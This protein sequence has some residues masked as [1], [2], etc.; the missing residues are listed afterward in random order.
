MRPWHIH[1][2]IHIDGYQSLITQ[3]F[4]GKV[5]SINCHAVFAAQDSPQADFVRCKRIYGPEGAELMHYLYP[6]R[7][8]VRRLHQRR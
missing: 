4:P 8:Q 6:A 3:L 2:L 5:P 1:I 7:D